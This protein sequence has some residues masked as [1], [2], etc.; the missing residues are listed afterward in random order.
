MLSFDFAQDRLRRTATE[1][2][3]GVVTLN[4]ALERSEGSV[5]SLPPARG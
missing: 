1:N 2:D 4:L 3:T 5:K